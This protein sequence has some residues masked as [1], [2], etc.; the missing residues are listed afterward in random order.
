MD[1]GHRSGRNVIGQVAKD[2][3][4]HQGGSDI[5]WEQHLQPGL[6]VLTTGQQQHLFVLKNRH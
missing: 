3:P 6:D 5:V 1:A 4:V 2:D